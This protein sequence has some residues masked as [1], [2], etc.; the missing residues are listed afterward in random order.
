VYAGASQVAISPAVGVAL[1]GF[2]GREQPSTAV[3]DDLTAT[4]LYLASEESGTPHEVAIIS[5]DLLGI[6]AELS[7]K[8]RARIE[9]V[10][11][12]A[13]QRALVCC[14]H[15]HYGPTGT[16]DDWGPDS[17]ELWGAGP[18]HDRFLTDY[19]DALVGAIASA[20]LTAKQHAKRCRIGF[21][22]G[23][24]P[25]GINRRERRADGEV[26]IGQNPAGAYD[27]S[28]A[29]VRVDGADGSPIATLVNFACH[30]VSLSGTYRHITADFPGVARRAIKDAVGGECLIIQ[31]A[32]GDINPVCMTPDTAIPAALGAQLA[33]AALA[34]HA[35]IAPT[36]PG[37]GSPKLASTTLPLS[38][39][40]PHSV[41][42][43]QRRID[44]LEAQLARLETDP[45]R[46]I[47]ELRWT[48][49]RLRSAKAAVEHLRG[50]VSLP[51]LPAE[52]SA[53]RIAP[54]IGLVTSPTE[55]FMELSQAI[56]ASSPF[57]LTLVAG[58]TNGMVGYLPTAA[59]YAEGGYEVTHGCRVAPGS[60]EHMTETQYELL[61]TLW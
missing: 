14:T 5:C 13:A 38:P 57:P 18:Q 58:Y 25:I 31:G 33:E 28:V 43:G 30:A 11:G 61:R 3:D 44:A 24:A 50:D 47:S 4:A 60:A 15:T 48:R 51:D 20:V 49:N 2:A 54:E 32:A 42:E 10:S 26:V 16:L 36:D 8:V 37:D 9:A 56:R 19:F 29:V 6:G 12:I 41:G 39:L 52:V 23:Q 46:D 59:A 17:S 34:S 7:R 55:P 40:L 53:V 45:Q 22:V 1:A 35:E 27:P 21:G